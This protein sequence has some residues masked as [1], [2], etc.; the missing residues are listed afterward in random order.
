MLRLWDTATGRYV[1]K[2]KGHASSV[3]SVAFSPNGRFCLSGSQDK[4]LRLWDAATGRCVRTFAGG[5]SSTNSVAFSPDGRFCLSGNGR[6]C[7]SGSQDAM[8]RLWNGATGQC[9]RVFVDRSKVNSVAFSPDGR[10]CL[11][12]SLDSVLLLLGRRDGPLRAVV[13]G[14]YQV[15]NLRGVQPRRPLLP[16]GRKLGR[17]APTVGH[18]DAP[19]L[20]RRDGPLRADVQGTCFGCE[21]RGVQPPTVASVSREALTVRSA[22]GTLRWAV[23]CGRS[24]G[25]THWNMPTSGTWSTGT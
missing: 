19:P 23:A 8:L 25:M 16:L 5:I 9:V 15:H 1:R 3:L 13:R 6:F 7:L 12:G 22:F 4:T 20:G 10:F 17:F 24:R 21:F 18:Y 2:F 11:S 14:T